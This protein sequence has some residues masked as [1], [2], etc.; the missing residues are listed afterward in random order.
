MKGLLYIK[1]GWGFKGASPWLL[2]GF[3]ERDPFGLLLNSFPSKEGA[4]ISKEGSSYIKVYLFFGGGGGAWCWKG[5]F[6]GGVGV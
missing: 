3:K 4:L 5:L 1:R 2:F 6:Y